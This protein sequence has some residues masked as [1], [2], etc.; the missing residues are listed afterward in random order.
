MGRLLN[1]AKNQ[2]GHSLLEIMVALSVASTLLGTPAAMF[3]S[4]MDQK[5]ARDQVQQVEEILTAARDSARMR[6]ACVQVTFNN[7][8]IQVDQYETCSPSLA[9]L[10]ESQTYDLHDDIQ[11]NLTSPSSTLTYNPTGGLLDGQPAIVDVLNKSKVYASFEI[12][13]FLGSMK[14]L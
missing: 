4:I 3:R 2:N 9:N 11:L 8:K 13:P 6:S 7:D 5:I 12:R 10:L 1:P 14:R